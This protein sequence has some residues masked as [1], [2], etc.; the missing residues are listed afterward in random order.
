MSED[1]IAFY[2]QVL[3]LEPGSK[4]FF[5]LARLYHDNNDL[6][7]ARRVLESGLERHPEHFEARLLLATILKRKGKE[8]QAWD[9]CRDIFDLLK[10]NKDFWQC[11][12]RSLSR[13]GQK[14]LALAADFF[15]FAGS[16]KPLAWVDVLQSG[17]DQ[18][19]SGPARDQDESR[20]ATDELPI[21]TLD[22][23]PGPQN[24]SDP[25]ESREFQ[26]GAE[27]P[28]D[29]PHQGP[30]SVQTE[31]GKKVQA[32]GRDQADK[33]SDLV[34]EESAPE[35]QGPE[36]FEEPEELNDFDIDG[37]ARTRSMADILFSQEEYAKAL[38]IYEELWRKSLPGAERK[39]LEEVMAKTR[40]ALEEKSPDEPETISDS[41]TQQDQDNIDRKQDSI[42]FLN[43]LADR[44][45][46]RSG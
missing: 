23:D 28:W 30:G 15:V 40:S 3:E 21:K 32:P 42:S 37:E 11:V 27:Q 38:E 18:L 8:E 6:E 9:I 36:E 5:P 19:Q 24:Q 14:D 44:L 1:K 16:G 34:L 39:E 2:R 46:A 33:G 45:E 43:T 10:E 13:N 20:S 12:S 35:D 17:M 29:S 22:N 25:S 41:N 31:Q 26:A 4:L 7:N